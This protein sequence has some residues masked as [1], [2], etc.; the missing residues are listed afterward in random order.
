[1]S[2]HPPVST[3][4]GLAIVIK[5]QNSAY[6]DSNVYFSFYDAPI[7]GTINGQP[8][9]EYQPYSI[10]DIGSG[11]VLQSFPGGRVYFSLGQKLVGTGEPEP[12][13]PSVE[14]WGTRFDKMEMTYSTSNPA[15]VADLTSI[16]YFAIPL[17]IKTYGTD[18]TTPVQTLTVTVPGN[19][20]I[21]SLA[22]L[23]GNSPNV[24][25]KDAE[26]NFLRVLGP[27]LAPAGSYP[28]FQSYLNEAQASG[29]SMQIVDLYSQLGSTPATSTQNYNFTTS[30][31][32]SG[33]LHLSGGGTPYNNGPSVGPG[34]EIVINSSDLLNGI[35]SANPPYT[36]DGNAA[37]IADNDVYAAAVRDVLAAFTFGFANSSVTD[38]NT[39]NPFKN[40]VSNLWWK[41]PKAF[42]FLQPS[43]PNYDQYAAYLQSVSDAYGSPFADRWQSVQAALN[44]ANVTTMEIDVLPDTASTVQI[45]Q[46]SPAALSKRR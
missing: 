32:S 33:N 20:V 42:Q 7:T 22:A 26:G 38:P 41:S 12:V 44:P 28:S 29:L 4:P 9:V 23:A 16:D 19:T 43:A 8:I 11:I 2:T 14:N 40:E 10:A 46:V 30:F 18:L 1:M 6:N 45:L 31:D 13:N 3:Q 17:A 25:L 27:N 37:D 36:V 39:G 5:N 35:Y 15:G 21:S 34:H 24:L